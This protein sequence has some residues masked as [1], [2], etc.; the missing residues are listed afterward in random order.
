MV[1]EWLVAVCSPKVIISLM[2]VNPEITN[3]KLIPYVRA[4]NGPPLLAECWDYR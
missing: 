3:K 4:E 2:Q 1:Y